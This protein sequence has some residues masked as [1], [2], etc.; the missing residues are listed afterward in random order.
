MEDGNIGQMGQQTQGDDQ[1]DVQTA[2]EE[3][4]EYKNTA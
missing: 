3:W 2:E 1:T 4:I